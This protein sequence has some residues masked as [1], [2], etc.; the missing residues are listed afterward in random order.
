[1]W[2]SSVAPLLAAVAVVAEATS[3]PVA[4]LAALWRRLA[5]PGLPAAMAGLLGELR[6]GGQ[7]CWLAASAVT[8][9]V[10]EMREEAWRADVSGTGEFQHFIMNLLSQGE[11]KRHR[12]G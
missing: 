2:A 12:R 4:A 10:G 7:I 1:M 3:G 6:F 9:P 8:A 5:V 11:R